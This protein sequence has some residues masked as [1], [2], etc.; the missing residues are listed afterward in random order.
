MGW[1]E[2]M[3]SPGRRPYLERS[4][5]GTLISRGYRRTW[6]FPE[7]VDTLLREQ[8]VGLSV[9]H[10]FGGQAGWGIRLDAD[11]STWPH[12]IGNAFFPPFRCASFDAVVCD[13]PYN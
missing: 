13:P 2:P 10:L 4:Y 11:A 3:T 6:A 7:N 12:V 9:L 5:Q 8:L 1:P